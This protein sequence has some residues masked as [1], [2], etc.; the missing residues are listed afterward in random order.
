[1]SSK[2]ISREELIEGVLKAVYANS[3]AAVFFH[4]AIAE[5]VGLGATEEKTMLI[6]SAGPLTA[7]EIAQQ[8]GLTTPSVTSLIDRLEKKGFVQRVRDLQDRRRVI[9][10]LNQERFA[11]LMK[12]FGS[13]QGQFD[14]FLDG[15]SDEQLST[16]IDFLTRMTSMSQATMATLQHKEG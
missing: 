2:Q 14:S 3:T 5:Q 15:Y 4:T 13:L 9:V 10:E 8:T 1:L 16:I 6:L 7:G 12:V 11:E